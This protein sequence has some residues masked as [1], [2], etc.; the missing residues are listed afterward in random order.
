[1]TIATATVTETLTNIQIVPV[2]VLDD[3]SGANALADALVEGGI[4]CAEITLRTPAGLEALKALRGRTDLLLGAGTVLNAADVD[5][6]VD[7]G[8]QFIVSPGFGADVVTRCRERGVTAIPGISTASE[9]QVAVAAGLRHVKF[10]PAEQ[11]GGLPMLTALSGPFPDVR[12]M[13]SGGLR[14][15]NVNT[16]LDHPAVFAAGGSWMVPRATIIAGHFSE[17]ARLCA[18][19]RAQLDGHKRKAQGAI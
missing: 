14:P 6:A 2:V 4:P 3:P 18:D 8:A 17:V 9:L 7:A 16:Y 1:M 19:T 15:D 5:L 10:F 11:A 12:F 13:P